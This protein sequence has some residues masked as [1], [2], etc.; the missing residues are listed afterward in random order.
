M[1]FFLAIVSKMAY[2]ILTHTLYYRRL[3]G[4]SSKGL[5][6]FFYVESRMSNFI[7]FKWVLLVAELT[8][9]NN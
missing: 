3:S 1:C 5:R 4:A 2:N 8:L 7:A 6:T 9:L